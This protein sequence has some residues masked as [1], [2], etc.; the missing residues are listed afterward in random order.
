ML[1]N[2]E[3]IKEKI[4]SNTKSTFISGN[5]SVNEQSISEGVNLFKKV[6]LHNVGVLGLNGLNKALIPALQE[7]LITNVGNIGSLRVIADSLEAYLKKLSILGNKFS[8][9]EIEGKTLIPLLKKL[10]INTSLTKQIKITDFPV[11]GESNLDS[12]KLESEYLYQICNATIIRN[13]V[14]VSPDL[15]ELEI[16][17]YL[18][19]LLVIYIYS[20]LK[21]K[22]EIDKL[23]IIDLNS[24]ISNQLLNGDENKMLFDFIS[25]GNTT[26]E[27]KTQIIDAYILHYLLDKESTQ[28]SILKDSA[29]VYFDKVLT[30]H[31]Y[32]RKIDKLKQ[33]GKIEYLDSNKSLIKLTETEKNRICKVQ[34][35]F[36]D[37]KEL[38]LLYFK[39]IVDEFNL[40][41]SSDQ[42][43]EKLTEFFVNN[44]DIDIKEIY[45]TQ[46]NINGISILE[47]FIEFLNTLTKN[48]E[49]S[50]KL[51]VA[52]LKLCE[53]SDFIIRISASKVI[54]KL[55][56]P[57]SFQNYV[58]N[59]KRIVYID[60]QLVLHA[61]CTGYVRNTSFDNIYFQ[62][63]EELINYSNENL[64]IELRFSKLYLSE[65]ANQLKT[66]LL[67][68]PFEEVTSTK[69]STNIFYLFYSNLKEKN[70]L[71]SE[72]N[73]F[74]DFLENWLLINEDDALDS[75]YEQI[76]SSNI[77][78]ILESELNIKVITL[79]YYDNRD[80]AI[81]TLEDT[82]RKNSLSP[83]VH[84]I[85]S[86][87]A[88][89][90][91]HL[92]NSKEHVTEPFF[93]TWDKT[94]T[95]Y[96][97]SYKE[98][99]NRMDLISWHL[100]NPSKFLNHMSLIDFKIEPK[101]IT[102]EY[103][104][105][106]DS[107]GLHEKSRTIFD[108]MNRFLDIKNIS[109]LQRRKY[110]EHTKKIFNEKEF[111]YEVNLPEEEVKGR[112]S[113]P[114]EYIL[115]DLN[116]YFRDS[117][118]K[119]SIDLYRS[120][121]LVEDF[122]IKVV[123]IVKNEIVLEIKGDKRPDYK[124]SINLVLKEYEDLIKTQLS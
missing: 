92:T 29:D 19:D 35:D 115:D 97:K 21:Y 42:I 26:T 52:I 30:S 4:I 72:D 96:R 3:T 114:F 67:L 13:K 41:N 78:D 112:I 91:C 44:F 9:A 70:L 79:P 113:K 99:F 122:F 53:N 105:I 76:I 95:Y 116:S 34:K 102:N 10:E 123:D 39:D 7:A 63:I 31:F 88:L 51:V 50:K 90:V 28:I 36:A 33:Q 40:S 24:E 71:K 15:S 43:L 45:D 107:F 111:S 85:L 106:L 73:S 93:L 118:S 119:Y 68:I 27:I 103:L 22:T 117:N 84:H 61:L 81:T 87:D 75:E 20:A 83:K 80:T 6:I 14:H 98:K 16:L 38:F 55:T 82:I 18:K 109:K 86:N 1:I 47:S 37:N 77:S 25:F 56:N 89:M 11:L 59:Q 69:L 121:L 108:N 8:V 5:P 58:R 110:I 64:N 2:W 124:E 62:I 101:S 66:A 57:E 17:T 104:S 48:E 94:F 74:A 54:G 12:F 120:M 65:V 49:T 23:V 100:F 32:T 46:D 60:T